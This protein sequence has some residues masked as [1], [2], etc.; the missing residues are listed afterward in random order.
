MGLRGGLGF[1][2]AIVLLGC[3]DDGGAVTVDAGGPEPD[4]G[5]GPSSRTLTYTP[6]GCGY[7]VRT[8]EV[9]EAARSGDAVGASPTPGFVHAS[10]A[11][12]TESSFA[13]DWRTDLDTTV[14]QVLFGTDP[15]AVEAA[16]GADA[17]AGVQVRGGHH[18]LFEP[19]TGGALRLHEAHVCG[20]A[21]AT[22]HYY[23]VGGPG[24]WSA[25]YDV[26]TAPP[27]GA[28]SPIRFAVT[29]DSRDDSVVWAQVQA[30]VRDAAPDFQ[31]FTGD[32]VGL[33]VNQPEWDGFYGESYMG[34][35]VQE[36]LARIPIMP[37]NG[38][39]EG[40]AVNYTLQLALP[41]ELSEG[42]R[43]EG[44]EWYS[45]D[46]GNAHFVVLNDTAGESLVTGSQLDWL[47]ADLAAVDRDVTPWVFA[48]HH[49]GTYSCSTN[50]G[51]DI[52]LRAAWQPVFDRHEVDIVFNGHDHDYERSKPIRG[53]AA[54]TSDGEVQAWGAGT[55]YVVSGGAG[56]PL[57]G[58]DDGCYHTETI[59]SVNH[60]V[61]VDIEDRTLRYAAHRLDG[62]MLDSF[63]ITK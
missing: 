41:Q 19:L 40:L 2:V 17:A 10:F 57:Y 62:T 32:A 15:A 29:G 48:V 47:D 7:E 20:L 3:G 39:H 55:I 44:E 42:E 37:A 25:V 4:S 61:I 14:S 53:F 23:K 5:T 6:E 51:S 52:E 58:V 21:A 8:P 18:V 60:Y 13:V 34:Q 46:Y 38:N 33:G 31:L 36:A 30:R 45:F 63:E 22:T 12:P 11:G 16:D 24:A 9:A 26:A 59:E 43:A 50:H 28:T 27:V 56:A 1:F 35:N 54:G 49:E